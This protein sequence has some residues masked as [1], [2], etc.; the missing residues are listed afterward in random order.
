MKR[1]KIIFVLS[2]LNLGG[3]QRF[4]QQIANYLVDLGYDVSIVLTYTKT[5]ECAYVMNPNINIINLNRSLEKYPMIIRQILKIVHL[6][7][8]LSKECPDRVVSLLTSVNIQTYF[9]MI[10][11]HSKLYIS[12]R[13]FPPFRNLSRNTNKLLKFMFNRVNKVIVQTNHA[14]EY[15]ARELGYRNVAVLPNTV[16]LPLTIN[17]ETKRVEQHVAHDEIL[18]LTAGRLVDQKRF[19]LLIREFGKLREIASEKRLRLVILG[20]GPKLN[21]LK[22][23]C[24]K[25]GLTECVSFVGRV[26][27]VEDWLRRADV[28]VMT[29]SYEGF[30]NALMEALA[31]GVPCISTNCA[32]GPS[33]MISHDVNGFLLEESDVHRLHLILHNLIDDSKLRLRYSS[34]AKRSMEKFAVNGC[35]DNF[36]TIL[37]LTDDINP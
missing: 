7:Q 8:I 19:D 33:E 25:R 9:A 12:E 11:N 24:E 22:K 10:G 2:A 27:N 34:Q 36:L 35:A 26:G 21:Y 15:L 3:A 16:N 32:T 23:I 30:P 37:G 14:K 20:T 5:V 1:Q 31:C 28:Y 17:G 18:V 13:N 29:S 6:R 4:V